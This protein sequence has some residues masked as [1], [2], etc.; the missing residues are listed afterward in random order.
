MANKQQATAYPLKV[1]AKW[2]FLI[3]KVGKE[4]Q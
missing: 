2:Y 1:R 3:E 4:N